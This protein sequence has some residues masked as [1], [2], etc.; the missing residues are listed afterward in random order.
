MKNLHI[1]SIITLF[2]LGSANVAAQVNKTDTQKTLHEA[3]EKAE[4]SLRKM[5][6]SLEA[7]NATLKLGKDLG[8]EV[9]INKAQ[10]NVNDIEKA[11]ASQ[12]RVVLDLD[13]Q[14]QNLDVKADLAIAAKQHVTTK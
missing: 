2:T 10:K 12:K 1:L 8:H 7:A 3:R 13:H 5:Q 9:L 6:T 14:L 4:R 11:I